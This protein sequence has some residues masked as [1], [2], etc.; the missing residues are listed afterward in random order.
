[1]LDNMLKNLYNDSVEFQTH[2]VTIW[3]MTKKDYDAKLKQL[4]SEDSYFDRYQSDK[5]S[6]KKKNNKHNKR[7]DKWGDWN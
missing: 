7:K 5:K 6:N 3:H 4:Q 1:M 2:S